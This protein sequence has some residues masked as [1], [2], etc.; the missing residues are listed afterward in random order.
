MLCKR[1]VPT[2]ILGWEERRTRR[3]RICFTLTQHVL[4]T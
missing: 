3:I 2:L 4:R 1:C